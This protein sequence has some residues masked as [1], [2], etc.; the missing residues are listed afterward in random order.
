MTNAKAII[1]HVESLMKNEVFPFSVVHTEARDEQLMSVRA[2]IHQVEFLV[3]E[4]R[5]PLILDRQE[6]LSIACS[7]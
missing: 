5:Y 7:D 2:I 6:M 3:R 1:R 4:E